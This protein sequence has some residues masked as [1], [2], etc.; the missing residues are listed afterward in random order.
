MEFLKVLA[1]RGPNIWARFPVLEAWIDLE[2]VEEV[3]H[4][5]LVNGELLREREL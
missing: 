3:G 5:R 1:L 4:G 2:D